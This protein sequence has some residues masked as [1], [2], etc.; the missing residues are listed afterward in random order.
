[1]DSKLGVAFSGGGIRSA[2]FCSGVLRR[3]L[4]KEAE[5][6]YLSCVSGGGYTGSAYVEWKYRNGSSSDWTERFFENMR[7]RAG[8]FCNW[9]SPECCCD[10]MILCSLL[11]FVS[12]FVPIVGWGS[13]AFPIAFTIKLL[14]GKFLDGTKCRQ[15]GTSND[16]IERNLLF[17][18]SL[19]ILLLC[20]LLEYL[21]RRCSE[22]KRNYLRIKWVRLFL[23]LGQ[24]YSGA[25][26]AFTFLPWFIQDFLKH[27]AFYIQAG[28]VLITAIFWFFLPLL[29]KYSSLVILVYLYSY[30]VYWHLYKSTLFQFKY[31]EQGFKICLF[32]SFGI[33][34]VFSILGDIPLRLVH[35]YNRWRLQRA[36]YYHDKSE[37]CA[38]SEH[39]CHSY[40][41][42]AGSNCC[43]SGMYRPKENDQ[44]AVTLGDLEGIK[45]EYLSNMVINGWRR[46]Y[47]KRYCLLTMSSKGISVIDQQPQFSQ[48]QTSVTNQPPQCLRDLE[49]FREN[50]L[51]SENF[52]GKLKP[53]HVKLSSAMAMSAA[54]VSPSLGKH[55]EAEHRF[56]HIL[57]LLGMEMAAHLIYNMTGEKK[58][59]CC[60]RFWK[61]IANL[62][63]ALLVGGGGFGLW[64]LLVP[65][66]DG[67][68]I[69]TTVAIITGGFGLIVTM[70]IIYICCCNCQDHS[71]YTDSPDSY[72]LDENEKI[73]TPTRWLTVHL[74]FYRFLLSL[75]HFIHDGPKPPAMLHLSDG[76]HFENYGLLPLLKLRLP[77][78]LVADGSHIKSD[79]DYGKEIIQIM[80]HAREI[81]DCSFTAMDGGDVLADIKK[82]YVHPK[83]GK[84]PR[85]YEFKV[86]YSDEGC[87]EVREGHIVL[88]SPRYLPEEVSS[89]DKSDVSIEMTERGD[90]NSAGN[91][92]VTWQTVGENLDDEKW[93]TGPSLL[94]KTMNDV[95]GF[96]AGLGCCDMKTRCSCCDS[97]LAFPRHTTG[98]QFFTPRLF[99]VYHREGYRA[100]MEC[101]DFLKPPTE[102]FQPV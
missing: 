69:I 97:C 33:L 40:G 13:F 83:D 59:G 90:Q 28:I 86:R 25:S 3:L 66:I 54:A 5:P 68:A 41:S 89:S 45:P 22:N 75:V 58:R 15:S 16:C 82:K 72:E 1:M 20:H 46:K 71:D 32:A 10:S 87:N 78:I 102:S 48:S 65:H 85:M 8:Y 4:K 49:K 9:Q 57:T 55:E 18:V 21:C 61:G 76:G 73:S 91:V 44:R 26:F 42:C 52:K 29:R 24:I 30:I 70:L 11:F 2:A 81:L 63:V 77:R 31:T 101:D 35:N 60:H 38:C 92:Q 50:C 67:L 39:C 84:Y 94:E 100:C 53:R 6:D 93:G 79:D 88:I 37:L 34:A 98:N 80:N 99:T 74:P 7:K 17:S 43:S 36:F 14:Y 95:S 23:K 56:T 27:S 19:V 62:T 47:D 51:N 64:K 12:V 96:P